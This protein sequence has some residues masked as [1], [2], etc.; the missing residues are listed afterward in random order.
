MQRAAI[1]MLSRFIMNWSNAIT[2]H[3]EIESGSW[4]RR[5]CRCCCC[6][7]ITTMRWLSDGFPFKTFMSHRLEFSS[8]R[9]VMMTNSE[10]YFSFCHPSSG[11]VRAFRVVNHWSRG[12]KNLHAE[13]AIQCHFGEESFST[14]FLPVLPSLAIIFFFTDNQLRTLN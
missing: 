1:K 10:Q 6:N 5:I 7:C 12:G 13:H 14:I 4:L 11:I 9:R 2:F 8:S 3:N